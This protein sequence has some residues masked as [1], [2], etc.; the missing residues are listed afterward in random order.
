MR[1]PHID[2]GDDQF[3][4]RSLARG[5]KLLALFTADHPEWT[6]AGLVREINL[7]KAT[8]YRITRT[9]EA[10]R[11]LIFNAATGTYHLGPS[12]VP[13]SYLAQQS[14]EFEKIAKPFL[15]RLAAETGETANLGVEMEDAIVITGSVL[16]S[17]AFKPSL[18][19]GRVLTDLTNAHAKVYAAYKSPEERKRLLAREQPAITQYSLVKPAE[20]EADLDRVA[21]EGVGFDMEEHGLGVCSA[22]APVRGQNGTIIGTLS[23][24]APKERFGPEEKERAAESVKQVAADFSAFMGYKPR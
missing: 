8:V 6:L 4:V 23:V 9:M 17:H 7:P 1:D 21:K 2:G 22:A 3:V 20:I 5:L 15:E 14:S 18:P 10:E 12:V 11:F 19:V 13:L 16:T 24:V